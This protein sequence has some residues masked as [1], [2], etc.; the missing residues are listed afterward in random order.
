MINLF[1]ILLLVYQD[2]ILIKQ[3]MELLPEDA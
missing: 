1:K 3:M 2:P